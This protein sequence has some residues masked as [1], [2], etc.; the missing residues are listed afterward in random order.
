[1]IPDYTVDELICVCISR[2]VEDGEPLAQGLATPLVMAGYLLA[3]LTHAANVVFGSAIGNTICTE[4][5]PLSIARIEDIWLGRAI[6]LTSFPKAVGEILFGLQ[7]KEFFRP[8]QIDPYGNFNNI[9]MGGS[10]ERP[11]LRLP[12]CGG[13]ADVTTYHSWVYLYVPRHSRAVFV[14]ELDFLSGLGHG[15]QLPDYPGPHYLVS[16]LGQFDFKGEGGRMR[17]V[18]YHPGVTVEKIQKKTGFPLALSPELHETPPPTAEE[19]RLL[20]EE[21]DPLGI[22]ELETLGGARRRRKL[23]E[24]IE[25]EQ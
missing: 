3:K 16:N 20:R 7:P 5:A 22:R 10:Y 24:I 1:M 18:S 6:A 11:H 19:V 23:R 13:I 14:E 2:Q 8:A 25:R 12:G 9:F 17:L 21:I 4:W 15:H